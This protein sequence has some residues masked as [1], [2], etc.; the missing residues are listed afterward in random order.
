MDTPD[1]PAATCRSCGGELVLAMPGTGLG[2]ITTYAAACIVCSMLHRVQVTHNE[3]G[4]ITEVEVTQDVKAPPEGK[5]T[6]AQLLERLR[7]LNEEI[8]RV[9]SVK[10]ADADSH[11]AQLKDLH[12]ELAE[13]LLTLKDTPEN[14]EE[15]PDAG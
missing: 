5:E 3:S 14:T 4:R 8:S 6:R 13:V 1:Q 7:G 2:R 12:Q 10:K 11:N 15:T 9:S